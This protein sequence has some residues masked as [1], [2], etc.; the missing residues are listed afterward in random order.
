MRADPGRTA[1]LRG[2]PSARSRNGTRHRSPHSNG[3]CSTLLDMSVAR[4]GSSA[5]GSAKRL[6][7]DGAPVPGIGRALWI[8][9]GGTYVDVRAPGTVA[10][11]TSFGGRSTLAGA[12][13]HVASRSRPAPAARDSSTA[14]SSRCSATASSNE[15]PASTAAPHRTRNG[16]GGCPRDRRG[17][18][19]SRPTRTGW[20][21]EWVTMRRSCCRAAGT[22]RAGSHARGSARTA[23]GSSVITLGAPADDFPRPDGVGLEPHTRME[24]SLSYKTMRG[25][26]T[27]WRMSTIVLTTT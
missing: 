2:S 10:S 21:Y 14:A 18:P 9:G 1:R 6:D 25:S 7:V 27:A 23:A 24:R 8:E 22:T 12:G 11:G 4:V 13:V 26:A 17:R 5:R 20:R 19:R 15:G 3:T 16:G